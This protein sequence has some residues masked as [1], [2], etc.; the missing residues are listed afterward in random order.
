MSHI[1]Q[2]RLATCDKRLQ[3]VVLAVF[4]RMDFVVLCGFRNERDQNDAFEQGRSKVKWPNSRHNRSPSKAVDLAPLPIDW[5]DTTRFKEL[6]A[7]MIEEAQ[8]LGI[9]LRWGGDFN[10]NGLPDDRFVDMPHFEIV[11]D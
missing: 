9:K 10:Q 11:G 1:S 4:Q 2:V 3:Q 6:A 7:I 5:K 8:R